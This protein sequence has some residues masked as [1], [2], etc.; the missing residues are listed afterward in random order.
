MQ[1]FDKDLDQPLAS[2]ILVTYNQEAYVLDALRSVAEQDYCNLE[3][4]V[5]D[6]ASVDQT[7]GRVQDFCAKYAGS[8]R[9][10]LNRNEKN[11]GVGGNYAKAVSLS[12]GELVFV[13][14]GDDISLPNRV[15]EVVR[16]WQETGRKFDLI[17]CNLID[18]TE[19]GGCLGEIRVDDLSAY[20]SL[21]DWVEHPPHVI[22]AA[23]AWTRRLYDRFGGLPEGVVGE[24]FILSFRAIAL[25][26]AATLAIPVVQY[27]RGGLTNKQKALN[28]RQVIAGLTKKAKSSYLEWSLLLRDAERCAAGKAV[29][30]YLLRRQQREACIEAMLLD[31]RPWQALLAFGDVDLAFKLRVFTYAVCPWV[32]APLFAFKRFKYGKRG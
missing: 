4:V 29:R 11:L 30:D 2:I 32:L 27:R 15:S 13:A 1:A 14:G 19:D 3:I 22:G 7:Y 9:F 25:G 26:S 6:D 21:N 20:H 28:T 23:Q 17:A 8:H 18:M 16:F 5:S 31:G 24:D 12:S 10:I